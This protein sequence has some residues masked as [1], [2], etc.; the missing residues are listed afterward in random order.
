MRQLSLFLSAHGGASFALGIHTVLIAWIS[1]AYLHL[2]PSALAWV[3]A[4]ALIPS[5]FAILV[6]GVFADRYSPKIILMTAYSILT[7]AYLGLGLVIYFNKLHFWGL[8][9]YAVVAGI[10]NAFVQPVR[11][12]LIALFPK[13][14]LQRR[15]SGASIIQF[16][17][18]SAGIVLASFSD[19]F[20]LYYIVA[21][22]VL[23]ALAAVFM[24]LSMRFEM[25]FHRDKSRGIIS[26]IR[27]AIKAYRADK[28]LTQLLVLIAFNGYMHMGVFLVVLP[29]IA[30]DV[31][32][33]TSVQYGLLQ[34][35]FVIGMVAAQWGFVLRSKIQFPG[36][37]ALFCLLYSAVVG[38]ALAQAPTLIGLY[39]LILFW[40]WVAGSSATHCRLV[41]QVKVSHKL[42]GKMMSIY[43]F[44]LFGLAP[45]GALATGHILNFYS[46]QQILK[47]MALSSGILFLLF[48]F[49]RSLWAVEQK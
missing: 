14:E 20:G 43:Q 25:D 30:R 31:Y 6:A 44:V 47:G 24:V 4:A 10:G 40:G 7:I 22:Q 33:F 26:D 28:A 32:G 34:L 2:S 41:L 17:S 35:S 27:I 11:E 38:F 37:G 42:R 19:D 18:Q 1:V 23:A 15:I 5:V 8:L 29:I 48:M 13:G 16:S 49:S 12:K 21:A 46:L 3:Q 45:L 9:C 39:T 36:Q